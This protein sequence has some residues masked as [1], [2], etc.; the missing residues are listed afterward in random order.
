MNP[1]SG[2][3][4]MSIPTLFQSICDERKTG[5][6]KVQSSL[7]EKC[8][9]FRGGN[10]VQVS[11]P[12]KPSILAE[13]LRRHP[14]LDEES[15]QILC[16]RQK[17]TG[18][19]LAS[20]ILEDK[21]DGVELVNAICSFQILEEICELFTWKEYHCEFSG[22]DPDP[23]IFD[24]EIININPV[25]TQVALLEAA[26]RADEWRII[27][28]SLPSKTDI[29]CQTET[30]IPEDSP[31]EFQNVYAAVDGFRTIEDILLAVRLSP[32]AAM[33]VL[34][35]LLKR[36][37]I[38]LRDAEQLLQL[39]KL[40]I[41]REDTMKRT[42]LYERAIELGEKSPSIILW[43]AHS[44]EN[45]GMKDKS[46]HLYYEIGYY[47]LKNAQYK[48]AIQ[49]LEK[50]TQINPENLDSQEKL[51][52]LLLKNDS[53]EEFAQKSNLYARRLALQGRQDRAMLL[54]KEATEKY[55]KYLENFDLLGSLYQEAGYKAQAIH[56]YRSVA[57]VRT[58]KQDY[59][60]AANC[61]QKM[62]QIDQDN[63]EAQKCYGEMLKKLGQ[64][65]Q[66]K[67]QFQSIG[68]KIYNMGF[69]TKENALYL[70]FAANSIIQ[71]YP[72]DLLARKWL[73]EAYLN[74]NKTDKAIEQLKEILALGDDKKST[75]FLVDVLRSLVK[76]EPMNLQNRFK[77]AETY[78]KSKKEREAIQEYFALGVKAEESGNTEEALKAFDQLLLCDPAHYAAHLKKVDILQKE[79]RYQE[80][81]QE[82]ILTGYISM[83]MDKLWQAI[84][85]FSQVLHMDKDTYALCYSQL[86][87]LY[88]R[89]G[90]NKEAVA[91][92]K[93]HVQKNIKLNNYT[94]ALQSCEEI[95]KI[96][97]NHDWAQKAKQKIHQALPKVQK[98]FQ[99]SF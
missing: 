36:G 97:L 75:D 64:N 63:M 53:L 46:A 74:Q 22:D 25:E 37:H 40:D 80:A 89:L 92:Y 60:G 59:L 84:R 21:Q 66:A 48:E 69:L 87:K 15:Y 6:L 77:L 7:G 61:Y 32:F 14:D 30:A 39:A 86:G 51:I 29:P 4:I 26:R 78:L 47:F 10:I 9:Y 2:L 65:Q 43:L 62:V 17:V 94:E 8:I 50:A 13:G 90:K 71:S 41:F 55:P 52:A 82:L 42:K 91:A 73:S 12:E 11:T 58:A 5:T 72:D 76:L 54:L 33:S 19:S 49:A 1:K 70:E 31:M 88:H 99:E 93:K 27:R 3:D 68:E 67:E 79:K 45:T 24:L 34:H 18:Q 95:L 98:V 83:G 44:Y 56:T 28:E 81:I 96:E 16:Q 57:K 20:L 38:A 23:M 35:E 85:A